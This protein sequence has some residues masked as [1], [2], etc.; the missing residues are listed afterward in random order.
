MF[1]CLLSLLHVYKKIISFINIQSNFIK[2]NINN[3][4]YNNKFWLNIYKKDID[5]E[6]ILIVSSLL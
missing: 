5:I 4:S 3:L 1:V 6:I 2:I